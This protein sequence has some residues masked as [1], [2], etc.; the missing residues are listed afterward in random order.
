MASI[1][2]LRLSHRPTTAIT[3]INH[4]H[5]T[6]IPSTLTLPH[7]LKPQ[8]SPKF[9][10]IH[11]S[12]HKTLTLKKTL[13][14]ASST[15]TPAIDRLISA[16]GYFLPFINGLQYGRFLFAQYP[17]LS[18]LFQPFIPI[19][20]LLKTVPYASF[21]AFFALYLG[22]VR[23]PNLSRYVR[24]NAMQALV[25]DVLLV[26]PLL[27][28]RIFTPGRAGVGFKIMV[29]GHNALF[30]FLVFCFVYSFVSSL[31]GRTPYLP[32]VADAAGRQL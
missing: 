12:N 17:P 1:Q 24:F 11:Q 29:M 2:L 10:T 16:V 26:L 32:F 18:V 14:S 21:V 30:V 5:K 27:L 13:I 31:L 23:N 19:F 8:F 28:Q 3:T 22:V 20:S 15:T 7:P 4:R 6:L 25:L 9:L